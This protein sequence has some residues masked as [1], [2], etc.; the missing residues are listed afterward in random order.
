MER[1]QRTN[2]DLRE[3]YTYYNRQCNAVDITAKTVEEAQDI[4]LSPDLPVD[5]GVDKMMRHG[6]VMVPQLLQ[7]ATVSQLRKFVTNKNELTKGTAAEFPVSQGKHRISYG[8]EGTEDPAVR[9]ALREIYYHPYFRRLLQKLLGDIDPSLSEITAITA[10]AG[11]RD[12]AWHSDTKAEGH[13]TQFGRTY[14]HSYSLFIPLQDTSKGMGP[15]DLC[16]GT[17]YCSDENMHLVCEKYKI[18]LH[19]LKPPNRTSNNDK[20]EEEEVFRA[21][22]AVLVN[23][24]TWHRGSAHR[25]Y[26]APERVVF[27]LSF[28]ARPH[29]QGDSVR[30]LARGTYFHMKWNMWGSTME[31]MKDFLGYPWS[32]LR[33]MHVYKPSGRNFGFDLLTSSAMRIA[34][35]QNG[36]TPGDLERFLDF[37]DSLGFPSWL[38][39]TINLRHQ[40]AWQIYIGE[41]IQNSF[42]FFLKINVAG[43]VTYLVMMLLLVKC[44]SNHKKAPISLRNTM[45]WLF[46][47][48]GAAIV[49]TVVVLL[50][51]HTS[52]WAKGISSG[53]TL[54]RPFATKAT[55]INQNATSVTTLPRRRDFLLG[56][57]LNN[58]K[59][60]SYAK[61]LDYHPGNRQFWDF[62]KTYGGRSYRDLI[63][64][65]EARSNNKVTSPPPA[66]S[67]LSEATMQKVWRQSD[68]IRQCAIEVIEKKK[69]RFLLQDFRTGDWRIISHD[70]RDVYVKRMLFIGYSGFDGGK[71]LL[72]SLQNE[73]DFMVDKYRFGFQYRDYTVLSHLSQVF[74]DDL[75][76]KKLFVLRGETTRPHGEI[77]QNAPGKTIWSPKQSVE[78]L[79]NM[80]NGTKFSKS[81]KGSFHPHQ[82]VLYFPHDD[83]DDGVYSATILGLS[84][85]QGSNS[86]EVYYDISLYGESADELETAEIVRVPKS[87]LVDDPTVV[88]GRTVFAN[89]RNSGLASGTVTHVSPDAL[90]SIEYDDG[91]VESSVDYYGVELP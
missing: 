72:A 70:Y 38:D 60:G 89:Y 63:Q 37:L 11:S 47:S 50:K 35:G 32:W 90:I 33:S 87:H 51:I 49:L 1:A 25:D 62:V 5:L 42:M 66:A 74:I 6:A 22:D 8:I 28:L 36:C 4:I 31:D 39:G 91:R 7:P 71:S 15:T 17:H 30:Q 64:V 85:L 40:R 58:K 54:M 19:Q 48:H 12:Q 67:S 2:D 61:W 84:T 26:E 45:K 13:G 59:I 65:E 55:G 82:D 78:L 75:A 9:Q 86:D 83:D 23:Q 52:P 76:S 18:G 79:K 68:F 14:H 43:L 53:H 88:E 46:W 81:K 34:N 77:T 73:L 80:P 44:R 16:P 10:Y 29:P 21:G 57:R 24:Q 20:E 41:T 27:I 69:G 3:E 56:T